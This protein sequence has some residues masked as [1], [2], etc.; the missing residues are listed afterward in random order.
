MTIKVEYEGQ[1]IE[2]WTQDEVDIEVKGLKITLENIKNEKTEAENKLK[3]HKVSSQD[4]EVQLATAQGDKEKAERL[5]GEIKAD[6]EREHGELLN[7][8]KTKEI[9]AGINDLVTKVG[10]G[11]SKNE[12]LRDLIKVRFGFDYDLQ[13]GEKKVSGG[14]VTSFA[15]L[16]KLV[17][18]DE[19][20]ASYR[21]GSG[22]SGGGSLG[23]NGSGAAIVNP[24]KKDTLNLTEQARILR[25]DPTLAAQLKTQ[26]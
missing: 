11:G 16:S 19:R 24:F 1:T 9:D 3:E 21:A 23:N 22:A 13:T 2:V 15:E 10:A 6:K 25:E 20:Y 12:D 17:A 8:I 14:G 7:T 26:V 18:E 5:T 4:L